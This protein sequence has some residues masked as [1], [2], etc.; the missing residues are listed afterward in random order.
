MLKK[1]Y[2]NCDYWV[3]CFINSC[4]YNN[5]CVLYTKKTAVEIL[6]NRIRFQY[7]G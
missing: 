4:N 5:Y 1:M 7:R 6:V 2:L 3:L